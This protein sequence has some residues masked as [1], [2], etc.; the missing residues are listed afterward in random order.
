MNRWLIATTALLGLVL[1]APVGA[2]T[3]YLDSN[4]GTWQGDTW[5]ANGNCPGAIHRHERV[6]GT[7][8]IVKG[9]LVTVQQS[10]RTVVID[11]S[12]A[13]QNQLTGRVAV[14]R[15]IV[16]HGYWDGANFYATMITTGTPPTE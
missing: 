1:I 11:D 2:Q 3:P 6:A 9:H 16:A 4:C 7:I 8:T 10:D 12:L 14:G 13:L 15:Q 5:V